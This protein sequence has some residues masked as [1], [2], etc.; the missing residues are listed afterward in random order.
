MACLELAGDGAEAEWCDV[1]GFAH[2]G[3]LLTGEG[4]ECRDSRVHGQRPG[5]A[6]NTDA[7]AA[8]MFGGW[9]ADEPGRRRCWARGWRG[10]SWTTSSGGARSS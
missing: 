5:A 2:R 9:H 4:S 6:S 8:V 1:A 7:V 10:A 3:V